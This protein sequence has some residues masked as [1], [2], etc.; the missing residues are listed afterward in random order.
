MFHVKRFLLLAFLF[1]ALA[2]S[3]HMGTT[4]LDFK[5]MPTLPAID[6][7]VNGFLSQYSETN[8]LTTIQK[9]WFYWTNYSR[10]NP[11]RFWDSIVSPLIKAYPTLNIANAKSLKDDLYNACSLPMLAPSLL[12][13]KTANSL[14][15]DLAARKASPSHTSPSGI[16]FQDRMKSAGIKRCAGEN[17][18]FGPWNSILMLVLLYID[19][20]VQDTGHRKSLLNAEYQEMGIGVGA[21]PN[22]NFLIVQDFG[23]TQKG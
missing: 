11:R 2:F 9:E 21:Y 3:Q 12:L 14:A 8:S 20:G 1:P 15:K 19:E 7:N 10:T 18:S 4:S 6:V 16:T 5:G 22:N 13:D 23:C 17:I